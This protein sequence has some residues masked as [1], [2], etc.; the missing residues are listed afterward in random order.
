MNLRWIHVI[1]LRVR[2]LLRREHMEGDLDR[3]LRSHLDAAIEE[4]VSLGMSPPDARRAALVDFG[5]VEQVREDSRDAR[6]VAI[7]ENLVRDLR[8]SLRGLRREPLLLAAATISIALGAAGNV[9]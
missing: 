7:V 9:A 6:G 5:G 1:R 2:S 4:Y 3:E 8:Y